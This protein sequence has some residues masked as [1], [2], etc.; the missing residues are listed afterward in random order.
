[1]LILGDARRGQNESELIRQKKE[2]Q[3]ILQLSL[4][5]GSFMLGYLPFCGKILIA[6]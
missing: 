3:A 6:L 5:V 4:I 1:V 2:N